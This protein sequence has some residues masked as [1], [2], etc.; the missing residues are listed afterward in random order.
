MSL[1]AILVALALERMLPAVDEL[2]NLAWFRRYTLWLLT[3]FDRHPR[4]QGVPTLLLLVFLPV[5]V[6]ALA[7]FQINAILV[8]LSFV[9]SVAVLLYCLGPNDLHRL[10]R[11]Y[12]DAMDTNDDASAKTAW[13]QL[14]PNCVHD[15]YPA[16]AATRAHALVEWVLIQTHE[17][18]LG[19]LFWFAVLGPMG[20]ILY[21]LTVELVCL[22]QQT[23]TD[24]QSLF[25]TATIHLHR[26]LAWIPS[27]L[28]ALSYAVMGSF[29]PALQAWQD[30]P[31]ND[32][33]LP[34]NH[35]LLRH[36]GLGSLQFDTQPPQDTNAV[37]TA[38]ALCSRSLL[39]WLAILALM[40]LAGWTAYSP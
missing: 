13:Q 34:D 14:R 40:T 36:T 3:R 5:G 33:N 12:L 39:T 11:R 1:L 8:F 28:T 37:R 15:E 10:V 31:P 30:S 16:D 19:I 24:D 18:L 4:W 27:H 20:A 26:V 35:N 2:R 32:Q 29:I 21:R 38:L 25:D 7:Q 6:T 22:R 9:F 23:P 17:R